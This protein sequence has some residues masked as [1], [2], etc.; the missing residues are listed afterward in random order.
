MDKDF[1]RWLEMT[2]VRNGVDR[3]VVDPDTL[4][5]HVTTADGVAG[6]LRQLV[7][8]FE[9]DLAAEVRSSLAW[10]TPQETV[11]DLVMDALRGLLGF[12]FAIED[13]LGVERESFLR[14]QR[15][16]HLVEMSRALVRFRAVAYSNAM[17]VVIREMLGEAQ[18]EMWPVPGIYERLPELLDYE[19]ELAND[20]E[21]D[22]AMRAAF[23]EEGGNPD[24]RDAYQEW[25]ETTYW[26]DYDVPR[27]YGDWKINGDGLLEPDHDGPN[28]FAASDAG[29]F[30][31]RVYW[32]RHW[33]IG[34][35]CAPTFPGQAD[36][37]PSDNHALP[38]DERIDTLCVYYALPRDILDRVI[39]Y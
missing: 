22:A 16:R 36:A 18:D 39:P 15:A 32:S 21:L 13:A 27:Y 26:E 23:R 2:L 9:H 20:L 19:D 29:E 8:D 12:E 3:R 37:R 30:Y 6:Y 25:L 5:N 38:D 1:V 11:E 10:N 14:I 31:V 28:G 33:A 35:W 7:R 24:D 17:L 4:A 34:R